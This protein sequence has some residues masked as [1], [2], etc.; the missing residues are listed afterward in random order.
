MSRLTSID[1][2]FGRSID[3]YA[4][5]DRLKER[6]VDLQLDRP[7][8]HSDT[9]DETILSDAP[10]HNATKSSQRAA[11]HLHPVSGHREA[12][13]LQSS[14]PL[15]REPDRREFRSQ[16][17]LIRH[18]DNAH[19][20]LGA[21]GEVPRLYVSPEKE[22]PWKQGRHDR[23]FPPTVVTDPAHQRQVMLNLPCLQVLGQR[24]LL[25]RLGM[26]HPPRGVTCPHA[27]PFQM[28]YKSG[29]RPEH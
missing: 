17:S 11:D 23:R 27:A 8:Q 19:D 14:V 22:I 29:C 9:E 26:N 25:P 3:A 18:R 28:P 4:S 21:L 1:P 10:F 5:V 24:L 16:L 20:A 12:R 7:S 2:K 6:T 13:W 15:E